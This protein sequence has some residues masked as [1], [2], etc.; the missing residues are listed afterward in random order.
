MNELR[1]KRLE[2]DARLNECEL[3]SQRLARVKDGLESELVK[4]ELKTFEKQGDKYKNDK[5]CK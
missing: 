5:L 2:I 4:K 3:Q 1:K